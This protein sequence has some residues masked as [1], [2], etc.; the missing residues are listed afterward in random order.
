MLRLADTSVRLYR[1]RDGTV[2]VR[3]RSYLM[4]HTNTGFHLSTYL[5][6]LKCSIQIADGPIVQFDSVAFSDA[7]TYKMDHMVHDFWASGSTSYGAM[8]DT[9][10]GSL[11]LEYRLFSFEGQGDPSIIE[12]IVPVVARGTAEQR[13][14]SKRQI[15]CDVSDKSLHP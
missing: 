5:N 2:S 3:L 15:L 1:K 8:C 10:V 11:R 6:K 4:I 14:G 9:T 12:L 7:C 13:Y